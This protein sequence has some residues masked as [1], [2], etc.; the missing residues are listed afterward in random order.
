MKLIKLLDH[1]SCDRC[2][3]QTPKR[4]KIPAVVCPPGSKGRRGLPSRDGVRRSRG[5]D[6]LS[7]WSFS[8]HRTQVSDRQT[9]ALRDFKPPSAAA[10][11]F[12]DTREKK[13]ERR[14]CEDHTLKNDFHWEIAVKADVVH[15]K[16]PVPIIQSHYQVSS[17]KDRFWSFT[18]KSK[19]WRRTFSCSCCFCVKYHENTR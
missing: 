4:R 3:N 16:G 7:L 18:S 9:E 13:N 8:S 1:I 10:R 5:A 2:S 15:I 19:R 12:A 6:E 17:C 14:D 11:L